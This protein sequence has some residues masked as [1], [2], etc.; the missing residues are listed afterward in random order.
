MN[1]NQLNRLRLIGIFE[2]AG[3]RSIPKLRMSDL[4]KLST[5]Y[6]DSFDRIE[7]KF[8][9]CISIELSEL[10][11]GHTEDEEDK[12]VE[13]YRVVL[14]AEMKALYREFVVELGLLRKN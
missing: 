4:K 12:I 7:R 6:A 3:V 11:D 2:W 13:K 9:D 14:D 1:V 8:H 10:S 5:K